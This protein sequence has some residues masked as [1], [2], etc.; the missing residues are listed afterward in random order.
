VRP[1]GE[2]DVPAEVPDRA[3][4][5]VA[6]RHLRARGHRQVELDP[7]RRTERVRRAGE[8]R[9]HAAGD[10]GDGVRRGNQVDH[11]IEARL[12]A[13]GSLRVD[14]REAESARNQPAVEP[15][16]RAAVHG[17][18]ERELLRDRDLAADLVGPAA[19]ERQ[20]LAGEARVEDRVAFEQPV[21]AEVAQHER[22]GERLG[23]YRAF[24][25]PEASP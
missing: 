2:F 12:L 22:A 9:G 13:V 8:P 23:E 14:L 18:V 1:G 17:E 10:P 15:L 7:C 6:D 16:H 5:R 4:R 11:R 19:R 3:A 20:R 21:E 25:A 24:A